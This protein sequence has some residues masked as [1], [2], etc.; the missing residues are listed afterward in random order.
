[1]GYGTL[2]RAWKICLDVKVRGRV[3][4]HDFSSACRHLGI[5]RQT[6]EIWK[7]FRSDTIVDGSLLELAE[8]APDEAANLDKFAER[9]LATLGAECQLHNFHNIWSL[10]D[11]GSSGK[12]SLGMFNRFAKKIKFEGDAFLLFHGLDGSGRGQIDCTDLAYVWKVSWRLPPES[13]AGATPTH[14]HANTLDVRAVNSIQIAPDKHDH[15]TGTRQTD[16]KGTGCPTSTNEENQL[17]TMVH[18]MI[19]QYGTDQVNHALEMQR[20]RKPHTVRS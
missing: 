5:A 8:V 18:W 2:L 19:K 20:N 14:R 1:M 11:P 6:R 10:L 12:A 7:S 16:L 13:F 17:T 3:S 9:V 15:G 4:Y